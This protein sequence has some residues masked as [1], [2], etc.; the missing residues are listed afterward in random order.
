MSDLRWP[1][2]ALASALFLGPAPA[3]AELDPTQVHRLLRLLHGVEHEY[4]EA[5]DPSGALVRPIELEEAAL[6]LAEAGVAARAVGDRAPGVV[7]RVAAL[8]RAVGERAP[9]AGVAAECRGIREWVARATGVAENVAPPAP[10]SITRGA[11]LYAAHCVSCHG[12]GGAG[13]GP[14]AARLQ[15]RPPDFTDADFMAGETPADFFLVISLGRR[16]AEMPGW[17][18]VLTLQERWDLVSYV[19]SLGGAAT[20]AGR[21]ANAVAQIEARLR[22]AVDAYR[23]QEDGAAALA[24]DAYLI[25][26]PLEAQIAV[27]DPATVLRVEAEFMRLQKVLRQPAS[28][29]EVEE[30]TNA[31]VRALAPLA[32]QSRPAMPLWSITALAGAAL[33]LGLALSVR[34]RSRGEGGRRPA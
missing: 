5:F 6:L 23:L 7:E 31:V 29:K 11:A 12:S 21:L 24:V 2:V 10:P 30:A 16:A 1:A 27:T 32:S 20:D 15:R 17:E 28:L 9:V 33:S 3:H 26:E 18:D 8:S 4:R 14:D 13:D 22:E 25:F 34:R 19:W